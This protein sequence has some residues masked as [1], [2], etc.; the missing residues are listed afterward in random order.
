MM[1]FL[2]L[3][4]LI[5]FFLLCIYAFCVIDY[6]WVYIMLCVWNS[7]LNLNYVCVW[8]SWHYNLNLDYVFCFIMS[9]SQ[10][11]TRMYMFRII[12]NVLLM[13]YHFKLIYPCSV[14]SSYLNF[15]I[16]FLYKFTFHYLSYDTCI[17]FFFLVF[18]FID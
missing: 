12:E 15:M 3:K 4:V 8:E 2:C 9:N 16:G 7:S 14:Y 17:I 11:S 10:L 5:F 13:L 18:V 6:N 1:T